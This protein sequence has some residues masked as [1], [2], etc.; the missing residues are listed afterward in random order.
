M[1]KIYSILT[2]ALIM[3]LSENGLGQNFSILGTGTAV[4]G[5]T[6]SSPVNNFYRRTVC[7]FVYT[8]AELNA[9][10]VPAGASMSQIG[11]YVT[12]NADQNKPGYTVKMKHVGV[13]NVA[14]ALGTTGWTTV[15]N[16]F[17]YPT[18]WGVNSWQMMP[19]TTNFVWNGVDNI[20]VEVC[21]SESAGWSST[22]Q[23]RIYSTTSGYRFSQTDQVGSS[24]GTSPASVSTNKPQARIAWIVAG[25][26]GTPNAGSASIS[27]ASGCAGSALTLSATGLTSGSGISY[28]WQSS[29]TGTGSWTNISGATNPT[30]SPSGPATTTFY[31]LVT[32]CSNGGATNNTNAISF[33]PVTC[34]NYTF[35]LTDSW[36][37]GWNGATMDVRIGPTVVATLG[38][39]FTNGLSLNVPIQIADGT[40]YNLFYS[41]GGSYPSEVGIQIIDPNGAIIYN[42]PA[43]AGTVGA[44]LTTWV[45]SCTPPV[46]SPTSI[47]ASTASICSGAGTN[48]TLTANGASGTVY[49]FV[50]LCGTSGSFATGT[51]TVVSPTVTTT[52]YAR[53]FN[54]SAWSPNCASITINVNNAPPG[55][56]SSAS[57]TTI[58]SGQ[59]VNLTSSVN[60]AVTTIHQSENESDF[61]DFITNDPKWA[62]NFSSN[63]GGT[64]PELW[65]NF[66]P[67]STGVM[68]VQFGSLI[69]ATGFS[70]LNFQFK[71]FL[72][73]FS[74]AYTLRLQTSPDGLTW[75]DRW[76]EV[77][78]TGN[79]G[80]AT[81]NVPLPALNNTSFFYRFTFDGNSFD[82]DGWWIDDVI[83]TGEPPSPSYSWVSS[84]TGFTSNL[85]NPVASPSVNTNYTVT[86]TANGCSSSSIV[87]VTVNPTPT[88][89]AT[90]SSTTPCLG[91]EVTLT[92]NGA[93]S[94][95]W[96][97]GV[98]DGQAF[99]PTATTTFTVTGNSNGCSA[100][101]QV[102]VTLPNISN[103]LAVNNSTTS[104]LVNQNSWVH[105]LD[106]NGRLIVS[107]NSN[108]QNLGTV[109]ATTF[110]EATPIL[111]ED[112]NNPSF[113]T[114][115]SVLDRHWVITAQNQPI[116]IVE[117]RL[118]YTEVEEQSLV[119][120]SSMNPNP[121]DN[122]FTTSDI[123]LTKF[124]GVGYEDNTFTNNCGNGVMY[125][126]N[127]TGNGAV[128]SYLSSI[129]NA[130]YVDFDINSFSEFWLHGSLNNSPLPVKLT[131][132]NA[133]C[134]EAGYTKVTWETESESN[135]SHFIVE[136]SRDGY[137]WLPSLP[138]PAAGT[139]NET[140]QYTYTDMSA[141]G[142][143]EGYYRLRQVDYDGLEEV[144]DPISIQCDQL[145]T[146]YMDVYPNPSKGNFTLRVFT[147]ID[148][149]DALV[150]MLNVNGQ[151]VHQQPAVINNG[152]TTLFYERE[153]LQ[154][155][156]YFISIIANDLKITPQ[157]I[158]IH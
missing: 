115:S 12:Q 123:A 70:N 124:S 63:A 46:P 53:N 18:N 110:I 81:V 91:Q 83:I 20:G 3:L 122:V 30:F 154:Q 145:Y 62:Y 49:W 42:L 27:V 134:E 71:H 64:S 10:G 80:P 38:S 45:G 60:S 79:I 14:A 137:A 1:N 112:C 24:C 57:P 28:Q 99:V 96:N 31:R 114:A 100:T 94:Y 113:S 4:N 130:S 105:F 21:W 158:I 72:A 116:N 55:L 35:V 88:V 131:S 129:A 85:Q 44:Q 121:L 139:S 76:T 142:H 15:V 50:G 48:V 37:D 152:A 22:G 98:T 52:Y 111:V 19:F 66:A 118:P 59:Q 90:A 97:N 77:N 126:Y 144:F 43:G 8:A 125:F 17:T 39:T 157:K 54:G 75:T 102:I 151:I 89:T 136:R 47:T 36:G 25:C 16:S 92:G 9:A 2:I 67:S 138:I 40:N 117:V 148:L 147:D 11:W 119:V 153:D 68:W 74:G 41:N 78:P 87:S 6:T 73:H 103:T 82:T 146:A 7:Q 141:G 132:F 150:M 86:A 84:P 65:F 56:T 51:S 155:G 34:C 29:P 93:A 140:Q 143:F 13:T 104:C 101:A 26:S 5:T 61:L 107:V 108:G 23:C 32:T 58:C 33:T 149:E 135:S 106:N 128:N 127:Q 95:S 109:D 120:E 156:V 69:N 133:N